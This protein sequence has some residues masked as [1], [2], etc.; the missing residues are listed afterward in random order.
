MHIVRVLLLLSAFEALPDP[1][2]PHLALKGTQFTIKFLILLLEVFDQGT[3][4]IIRQEGP[5]PC[6]GGMY[7]HTLRQFR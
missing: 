4:L 7:G 5:T 6:S 2:C 3:G 1:Y